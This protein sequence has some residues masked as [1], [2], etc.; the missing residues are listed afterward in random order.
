MNNTLACPK[1]YR[2]C[3]LISGLRLDK[4]HFRPT[5]RNNNFLSIGRVVLLAFHERTVNRAEY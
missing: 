5:G 1:Q 4:A 3:L 2:P